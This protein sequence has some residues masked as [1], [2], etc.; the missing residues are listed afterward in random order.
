[1]AGTKGSDVQPDARLQRWD[2]NDYFDHL[3]EHVDDIDL[4][5]DHEHVDDI[6]VDH[7]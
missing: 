2:D 6:D 4:D 5:V 7:T 1:M 3:D